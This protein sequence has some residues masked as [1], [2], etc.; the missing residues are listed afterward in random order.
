MKTWTNLD[1]NLDKPR[2][3]SSEVKI[4]LDKL[5]HSLNE[6]KNKN[7]DITICN[8]GSYLPYEQNI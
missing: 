6:V 2:Q 3:T 1:K 8:P 5:R 7:L 4:N